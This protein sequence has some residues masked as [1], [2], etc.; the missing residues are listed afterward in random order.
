MISQ[1]LGAIR[2]GHATQHPR[3]GV[4]HN[5]ISDAGVGK[6]LN[7]SRLHLFHPWT[8]DFLADIPTAPAHVEGILGFQH[9][10]VG[11]TQGGRGRTLSTRR[12]E[13]SENHWFKHL[14]I[15]PSR[16]PHFLAQILEGHGVKAIVRLITRQHLTEG[17][18]QW[19]SSGEMCVG[20][21][22]EAGEQGLA[23]ACRELHL[24]A[25]DWPNGF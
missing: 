15:Q 1:Q 14:V 22:R 11:H 4:I 6:S 20:Q 18:Y 2:E 8:E 12:K 3:I 5:E 19:H 23:E 16:Y 10:K 9:E 13:A 7:T 25:V 24:V 21:V 17:S